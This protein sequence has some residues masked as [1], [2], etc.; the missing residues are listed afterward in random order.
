MKRLFLLLICYSAVQTFAWAAFSTSQRKSEFEKALK[1]I[2]S[3]VAPNRLAEL[4]RIISDYEEATANKALAVEPTHGGTWRVTSLA[5]ADEAGPHIRA[6]QLRHGKPCALVGV[7]EEIVSD[8]PFTPKDMPRL[9]YDGKF[10]IKQI[11]IISETRRAAL[12]LQITSRCQ[13]RKQS[14]CTRGV[15]YMSPALAGQH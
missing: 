5:T 3:T 11:P 1:V 2:L 13:S 8:G 9:H 4:D 15:S 12:D 14:L 7:N 10:D 6:C